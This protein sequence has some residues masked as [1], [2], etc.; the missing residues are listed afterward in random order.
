MEQKIVIDQLTTEIKDL[1]ECQKLFEFKGIRL[2]DGG[3]K[4]VRNNIEYGKGL[5]GIYGE[6]CNILF[7]EY[8]KYNNFDSELL[9]DFFYCNSKK[10][11][12]NIKIVATHNNF[13]F[14]ELKRLYN[15]YLNL[16]CKD[17]SS[18]IEEKVEFLKLEKSTKTT[19]KTTA[20][21]RL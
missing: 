3:F 20:P 6:N 21:K 18:H 11:N 4:N 1:K 7:I 16:K 13:N 9:T 10:Q 5:V 17:L 19:T 14:N 12:A 8:V 2:F 15:I